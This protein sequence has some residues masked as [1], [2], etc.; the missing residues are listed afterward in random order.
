MG[1]GI[2]IRLGSILVKDLKEVGSKD[3]WWISR[4]LE[5]QKPHAYN[6]NYVMASDGF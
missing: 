2:G 6:Y 5:R 3:F 4:D 1:T